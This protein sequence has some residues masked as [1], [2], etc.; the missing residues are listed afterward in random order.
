[1][2]KLRDYQLS[3]FGCNVYVETGTG[4]GIT[5]GKACQSFKRCYSVDIDENL[6]GIARNT[7][8][9]ANIEVGYSTEVLERW[10]LSGEFSDSDRVLFFLDAHFP[11]ADYH[12]AKYTV[13]GQHAV[14]LEA[15]LQLIKKYR[16][17]GKDYIICDDARIYML[18]PFQ[19]G[20][21]ENLQVPGGLKFLKG[22]FNYQNISINFEEEGYVEIDNRF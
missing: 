18:G 16:P 4:T 7:Y 5:L 15:E 2:G 20:N 1:M 17:N 21:V 13:E 10:L 12:G 22:M 3:N 11:G 19:N 9:A 14:P 8:P 6:V